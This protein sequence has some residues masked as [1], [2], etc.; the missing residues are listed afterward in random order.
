M[1]VVTLTSNALSSS[2]IVFRIWTVHKETAHYNMYRTRKNDPLRQAIRVTVEAGLLYTI[3]LIVLL[4]IYLTGGEAQNVVFRSIVQIIGITF[5]LVISR[6]SRKHIP[7]HIH[8]SAMTTPHI[9]TSVLGSREPAEASDT[10]PDSNSRSSAGKA[11]S[12]GSWPTV[13]PTARGCN[14]QD[15]EGQ[16][17]RFIS[18]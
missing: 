5:N 7:S 13:K 18:Q 10:S 4:S 15:P 16:H 3:S 11:G 17:D 1:L 6:T 8:S 9:N 2:L 14:V 12:I